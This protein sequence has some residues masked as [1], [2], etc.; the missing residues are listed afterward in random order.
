MQRLNNTVQLGLSENRAALMVTGASTEPIWLENPGESKIAFYDHSTQLISWLKLGLGLSFDGDV[1]E[2]SAGAGFISSIIDET[3]DLGAGL[4]AIAFKG[5]AVTAA[6]N[7]STADIIFDADLNAIAALNSVGV[8]IRDGDGSYKLRTITGTTGRVSVNNGDGVSGNPTINID[9]NVAFKNASE[10]ITAGWQFNALPSSSVE[11]TN[12]DHFVN[13]T[14]VDGLLA[15]VRRTSVFVKSAI[16]QNITLS[17]EQTIDGVLTSSS[18]VLLNDQTNPA[19]NG[20]YISAAG[21]W[22][23]ATDMDS[24]GE[25]DGTFV[26]VQNGSQA[27]QFWYTVSDVTNLGTDPI[28]FTKIQV[29]VIDGSGSQYRV[30]VWSD[31]DTITSFDNFRYTAQENV[32]IGSNAQHSNN[33]KLTVKG[34]SLLD[35]DYNIVSQN[36]SSQSVFSVSN[37]GAVR[38]G[39]SSDIL[40]N[41]TGLYSA[42]GLGFNIQADNSNLDLKSTNL[43]VKIEGGDNNYNSYST[44][45]KATRNNTGFTQY[46][47]RTAGTFNPNG[48]GTSDFYE[49]LVN[50]TINQ[51]GGH[52]GK[53]YGIFVNPSFGGSGAADFRALQV[54]ATSNHFA[55]YSQSGKWRIDLGSDAEGDIFYRNASGLLTRLGVG[56]AN[57]VLRGGTT[58]NW[59]AVPEVVVSECYIKKTTAYT[60]I[61]LSSDADVKDVAGTTVSFTTPTDRKKMFVFVNGLLQEHDGP[62]GTPAREYSYNSAT[63]VITFNT[64]IESDDKVFIYRLP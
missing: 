1:L 20:I 15:G 45:L 48:S 56:G 23:R 60:S 50:P 62:G 12:G 29:G 17:G 49:F 36:S 55:M 9:S 8:M 28:N 33:T 34:V 32:V 25:V 2:S 16:G 41:T 30:T 19:Q 14:Y 47:T 7:G 61:N 38:I 4:T 11:P 46:N 5:A 26:I 31:S 3:T 59:G 51:Q 27:G 35:L 39:A 63:H 40:L 21:A 52:A 22:T 58:P 18:R 42:N 13:K 53:T 54:N 37:T 24:A 10:V 6:R 43:T 64:S 44:E 57:Q